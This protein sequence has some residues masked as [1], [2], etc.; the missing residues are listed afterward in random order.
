MRLE[1]YKTKDFAKV[2]SEYSRDPG[3]ASTAGTWAGTE[4]MMGKAVEKRERTQLSVLS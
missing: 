3:S 4:G 1:V 2:A